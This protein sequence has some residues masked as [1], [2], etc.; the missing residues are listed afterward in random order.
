[1]KKSCLYCKN[2]KPE[3][4]FS[5]EHVLPRAI[6][7]NLNTYNP[8]SIN[9]VCNRCN[10]LSGL[11]IDG[12]FIKSW[13]INN[14]RAE[15]AQRYCHLTPNTILPLNCFGEIEEL[16]YEDKICEFWLGPTG[17][18]IYHF[19]DEYPEELDCP[20]M[21]GVPPTAFK[22][23]ID[24]GFVFLFIRSNNPKWHPTI[25]FSTVANF[26]KTII[27]LGNGNKPDLRQFEDI[28]EN[29]KKLH[30]KLLSIQGIKHKIKFKAGIN[31]ADRFLCKL[32][33]GIG[34]IVLNP[35][36][37]FSQSADLLRQG[38]WT[39]NSEDRKML[40]IKGSGIYS[41]KTLLGPLDQFTKWNGGHTFLIM[42][43]CDILT[44]YSNFYETNS[45]VI[46]VSNEP[47][48]WKGKIEEGIVYIVSPS[49]SKA[50]G[51]INLADYIAHRIEPSM[52]NEALRQ[53]EIE[54]NQFE[55][56]PS[57]DI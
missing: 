4:E 33:L 35:E 56:L 5:Q 10:S 44:L 2:E 34:S 43:N 18:T 23:K 31:F 49:L 15:A 52:P 46:V 16:K 17:D 50:V 22:K 21:I 48:H 12:P 54:M 41:N 7:G 28:P 37:K 8:F 51:P 19:H 27:Y 30:K 6:G 14:Y 42:R 29:L 1:M 40:P 38:M 20:P 11:F 3:E 53:L 45:S 13:L 57:Y 24:Y 36:F 9:D 39:K 25:V 32:A 55:K 47:N 26:E